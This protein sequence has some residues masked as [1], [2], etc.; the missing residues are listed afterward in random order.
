MT[1]C[2]IAGTVSPDASRQCRSLPGH[3]V[4]GRAGSSPQRAFGMSPIALWARWEHRKRRKGKSDMMPIDDPE[5]AIAELNR[6]RT[7]KR[8]FVLAAFAAIIV[9]VFALLSSVYSD[10]DAAVQDMTLPR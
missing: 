6:K 1:P 8:I 2:S 7:Q 9:G 10:D 4:I 3:R 5:L